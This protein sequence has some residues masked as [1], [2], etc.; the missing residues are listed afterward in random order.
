MVTIK[1]VTIVV[2]K[3]KKEIQRNLK[4]YTDNSAGPTNA[5]IKTA[6]P[7]ERVMRRM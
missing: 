1:T 4:R 5:E 2:C 6:F 7:T 3:Q